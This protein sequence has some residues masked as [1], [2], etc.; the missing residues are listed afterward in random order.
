MR[1]VDK[2]KK[3]NIRKLAKKYYNKDAEELTEIEYD[4]ITSMA[5]YTAYVDVTI[6]DGFKNYT[7]FD[8]NGCAIN[9]KNNSKTSTIPPLVAKKARNMIC[10]YCWGI[11]WREISKY[12]KQ[13]VDEAREYL[14]TRSIMGKR[15]LSGHNIAIY[16]ES[17]KPIGRTMLASIVM[18]EALKLRYS[19]HVKSQSY[20]WVDFSKLMIEIE[21]SILNKDEEGDTDELIDYLT[22]DWLVIDNIQKK[23]R[24]EKQNTLYSDLLDYFFNLRNN[25]GK[26]TILVFKFDIRDKLFDFERTYGAGLHSMLENEK[27]LKIPL[28]EEVYNSDY[29]E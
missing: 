29:Y 3:K 10:K 19:H 17:K 6:P 24:S 13:G 28:S 14:R 7:I 18:K 15:Y 5:E 11:P 16:G 25:S 12:R 21:K 4:G 22:C 8:F 26:P 1:K 2:L 27:T 23:L 9:R 20:D